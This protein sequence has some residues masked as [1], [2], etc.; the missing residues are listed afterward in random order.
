M[1]ESVLSESS[2]RRGGVLVLNGRWLYV[3]GCLIK[4]CAAMQAGTIWFSQP[5]RP[6]RNAICKALFWSSD[7]LEIVMLSKWCLLFRVLFRRKWLLENVFPCIFCR[8]RGWNSK[9]CGASENVQMAAM[10]HGNPWW[11]YNSY[12]WWWFHPDHSFCKTLQAGKETFAEVPE[13]WLVNIRCKLG[14]VFVLIRV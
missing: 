9:C 11:I 2:R 1:P 13:A 6:R 3:S 14:S 4:T 10:C 8:C 12:R 7:L 5:G